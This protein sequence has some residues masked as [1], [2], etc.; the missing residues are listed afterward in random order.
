MSGVWV[1]PSHPKAPSGPRGRRAI[2]SLTIG[3]RETLPLSGA[4][5][6]S[7]PCANLDAGAGNLDPD[8][9]KLAVGHIVR[10]FNGEQV[11]GAGIDEHLINRWLEEIALHERSTTSIVGHGRG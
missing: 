2:G 1:W 6:V 10:R 7:T 11:V 5:I 3:E 4:V 9:V 8:L